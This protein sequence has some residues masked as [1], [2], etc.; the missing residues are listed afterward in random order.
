MVAQGIL[1]KKIGM[2]QFFTDDGRALPV[3]VVEAGPCVVIQKKTVD[4]D[5]YNAI[6][7][8]FM[9]VKEHRLNKPQRGHFKKANVPY[10]K[11]IK[12]FKTDNVN[13]YQVGQNITVDI[14]ESGN[15][16]DVT[17]ISLGKGFA[18]AIKRWGYHRGPMA[19][20]SKYHRRVGSMGAGTSPGR[21]FKSKRM[22]GHM[23]ARRVTVK[24]LEVV[25]VD[26]ERNVLLLKGS[27]PGRRGGIVEIKRS[28][29]D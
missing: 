7:V 1:G 14:F 28:A 6:Q 20:G 27:I 16:V 9:D 5:G 12:E 22:P 19:H 4:K 17:G 26:P 8:G 21:V 23:G 18:G 29:K 13:D 24:G 10:K 3:T 25:K 11:Y 15:K 2:M